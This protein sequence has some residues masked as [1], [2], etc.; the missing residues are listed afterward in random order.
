MTSIYGEAA[1]RGSIVT[2][3]L[4]GRKG[5]SVCGG[6]RRASI[7]GEACGGRKVTSIYGEAAFRSVVVG[8]RHSRMSHTRCVLEAVAL[9]L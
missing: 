8:S 6:A 7:R 2:A 3:V 5:V 4:T 1:Y 9:A